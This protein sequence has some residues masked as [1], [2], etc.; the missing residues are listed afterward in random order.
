MIDPPAHDVDAARAA[1]LRFATLAQP[2]V[3]YTIAELPIGR[4]VLARTAQ[5]LVRIAYADLNGT[6]DAIVEQLADRLS[7]RIL[8][9]PARFDD[10]RTELEEYF[11]GKRQQFSITLDWSLIR[12][13]FGAAVLRATAAIPYGS[14]ST[15]GVVAAEAGNI[16]ASRA[17]GNALGNNPIP[18]VIPCHRVLRSGGGLGGYTGG[19]ERKQ[20]LLEL[21][22]A[23][24]GGQLSLA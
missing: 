7:P 9:Q 8:E 2:D 14:V 22:G 11:A 5:G 18:I 24:S 1:A 21:E 17:T 20:A 12:G 6:V 3:A 10:V 13:R 16:A 23:L 19:L 4:V 15:Y